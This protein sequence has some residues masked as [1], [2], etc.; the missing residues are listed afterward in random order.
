[1]SGRGRMRALARTRLPNTPVGAPVASA[2]EQVV[3]AAPRGRGRGHHRQLLRQQRH[4]APEVPEARPQEA[5][6][7]TAAAAPPPAVAASTS[8]SRSAVIPTTASQGGLQRRRAAGNAVR[9]RPR[10]APAPAVPARVDPWAEPPGGGGPAVVEVP[11][12]E[13]VEPVPPRRRVCE[14]YL[15]GKCKKV[16]RSVRAFWCR[17]RRYS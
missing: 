16:R 10:P 11:L 13:A 2:V 14:F 7:R 9:K 6:V 8:T 5:P 3:K 1:M 4:N 15:E 17:G 12:V